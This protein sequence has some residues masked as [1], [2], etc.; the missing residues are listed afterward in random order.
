MYTVTGL[1]KTYGENRVLE[2]LSFSLEQGGFCLLTGPSGSG[3]TT[4]LHILLGL[5]P[6][7]SGTIPQ[8]IRYSM[9]FQENRLLPGRSA[10]QNLMPIAPRGMDREA[11]AAFLSQILPEDCLDR[12]V[13]ALS[14][15]M[16][17]RAAIARAMLAE[18]DMILMDEPFTG[19]DAETADTVAAF[20]RRHQGGRTLL[21]A[22]HQTAPVEKFD[23]MRIHL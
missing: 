5:I 13:E 21:M 23:P 7:D 4:L 20:I 9:V 17:R 11:V 16:Q 10:I 18:S 2:A 6:A 8:G 3:K 15:G 12:K 19:L 14:G 22:T 1:S